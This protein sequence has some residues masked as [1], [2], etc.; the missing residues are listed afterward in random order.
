MPGTMRGLIM[1]ACE[2]GCN[3]FRGLHPATPGDNED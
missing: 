3:G 2:D 1:G